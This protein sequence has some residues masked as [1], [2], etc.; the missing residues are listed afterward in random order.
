MVTKVQSRSLTGRSGNITILTKRDEGNSAWLTTEVG[1]VWM[2]A[3][4]IYVRYVEKKYYTFFFSF[5]V[6][7][8]TYDV[9]RKIYTR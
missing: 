9:Y 8:A 1:G 2:P 5:W 4:K 6:S 3:D 7:R